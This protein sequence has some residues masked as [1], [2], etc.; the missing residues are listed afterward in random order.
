[1]TGGELLTVGLLSESCGETGA[2]RCTARCAGTATARAP[3]TRR[4]APSTATAT[5]S[6]GESGSHGR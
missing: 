3:G 4:A 6:S 1:M 2:A 5:A